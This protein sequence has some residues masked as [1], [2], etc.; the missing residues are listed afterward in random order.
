M[1]D[2]GAVSVPSTLR[3]QRVESVRALARELGE[4]RALRELAMMAETSL[5]ELRQLA[6]RPVTCSVLDDILAS[7]E[8]LN[9]DSWE[10][11]EE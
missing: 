9:L 7:L 4:E 3:E 2:E 8:Q 6:E 11:E 10:T 5:R 1:R